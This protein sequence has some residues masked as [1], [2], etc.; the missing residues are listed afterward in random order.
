MS[1]VEDRWQALYGPLQE[2]KAESDGPWEI[3]QAEFLDKVGL[4]DAEQ[5]PVVEAFLSHLSDLSSADRAALLRT[6]QPDHL[7]YQLLQQS[8]PVPAAPTYDDA[9][10]LSYLSSHGP[11]WDGT[12][13]EWVPFRVWFAYEAQQVGLGGPA[14]AL[15]EYLEAQPVEDRIATFAQYGVTIEPGHERPPPPK[16]TEAPAADDE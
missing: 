12:E 1:N 9:A 3:R 13:P 14:L 10:W 6:E 15:L 8:A 5:D 7:L 16:R 11:Y 4:T 2:L